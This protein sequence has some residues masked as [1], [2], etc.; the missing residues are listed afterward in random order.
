MS[1]PD[2]YAI[3]DTYADLM[4]AFR[5]RSHEQHITR[6]SLGECAGFHGGYAGKLLAPVPI[7]GIGPVTLG[8]LLTVHGLKI[9]LIEDP[10]AL[11]R[12]AKRMKPAR[13]ASGT[14][15][16][17]KKPKK[18]AFRNNSEWGKMMRARQTLA[19]TPLQRSASA[20]RAARARWGRQRA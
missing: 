20:R 14:M 7:R 8:P 19:R 17:K 4:A 11:A 10:E 5:R 3:V 1:A 18:S 16:A 12:F 2:I 15:L 13:N 6:E 9:E